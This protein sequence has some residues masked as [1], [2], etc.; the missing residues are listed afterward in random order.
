MNI[1]LIEDDIQLG[2]SIKSYFT[3]KKHTVKIFHEGLDVIEHLEEKNFYDLYLVD[4]NIPGVNGLDILKYIRKIDIVTPVIVLTASLEVS[5]LQI[6][7]DN[8]CSEYIKKPFS[9]IELELRINRLLYNRAEVITLDEDLIYYKNSM[10][11][12]Y[13]DDFIKLRKKEKLF[14]DILINNKGYTVSNSNITDYVWEGEIRDS[15]PIRQVIN[16]IRK[17]IPVELI[18]TEIGIGYRIDNI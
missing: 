13:K 17:K 11:L 10:E 3:M 5:T 14:L 15:Y 12:K 6:A 8:N 16:T 7:F 1:L 4:V 2:M 18:K 9:L